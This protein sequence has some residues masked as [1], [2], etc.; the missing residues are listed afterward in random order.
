[1][2]NDRPTRRAVSSIHPSSARTKPVVA[3]TIPG[4]DTQQHSTTTPDDFLPSQPPRHRRLRR[5]FL[6]TAV[7]LMAGIA[8]AMSIGPA[9][10]HARMPVGG[11]LDGRDAADAAATAEQGARRFVTEVSA[12][13]A[14][15]GR[16]GRWG[17][18]LTEREINAWLA[19]DLPRNRIG[20][21][22]GWGTDPRIELLPGRVRA[23]FRLGVGPLVTVAWIEAEVRLRSVNQLAITITDARL[24][25]LPVPRGPILKAIGR[26]LDTLGAV[27]EIRRFE[28][29][30]VLLVY[31]PSTTEGKA[32]TRWLESLRLASGELALAGETRAGPP[33]R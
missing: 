30:S 14:A 13:Y 19:I 33:P 26:R 20:M 18:V 16:V 24:G 25:S 6:L 28:N 12:V 21:A 15:S 3:V 22:D 8:L 9:F 32:A 7:F 11:P 29:R 1:M 10:H 4:V 23:G 5:L 2:A 27:T 17:A 31:I